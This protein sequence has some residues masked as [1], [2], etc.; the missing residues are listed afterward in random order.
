MENTSYMFRN[1]K[2]QQLQKKKKDLL[3]GR[4]GET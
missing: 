2:E 1:L 4:S 3:T